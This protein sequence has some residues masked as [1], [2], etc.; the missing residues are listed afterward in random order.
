MLALKVVSV[1]LL[2]GLAV[3]CIAPKR[4]NL[5][6]PRR[7]MNLTAESFTRPCVQRLDGKLVC[8]GVVVTAMCSESRR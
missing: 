7:C 2:C 6:I 5:V 4:T 1:F 3:G 8:D